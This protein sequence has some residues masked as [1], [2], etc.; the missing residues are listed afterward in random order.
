MVN[1]AANKILLGVGNPAE[2]KKIQ[3]LVGLSDEA[4]QM[5]RSIRR[6]GPEGSTALYLLQIDK[7]PG[8]IMLPLVLT[9]GPEEV[10]AYSTT[11]EDDALRQRCYEKAGVPRTLNALKTFFPETTVT[12]YLEQ[13]REANTSERSIDY[14]EE[15]AEQILSGQF[16]RHAYLQNVR[17]GI[18]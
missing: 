9:L 3:E 2:A 12:T 16:D 11:N 8:Y 15:I 4:T 18:L 6:A 17:Y 5:L 7:A 14:I 1:L 13:L 10:W